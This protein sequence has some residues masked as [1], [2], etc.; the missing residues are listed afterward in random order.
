M[1]KSVRECEV[2]AKMLKLEFVSSRKPDVL[3][4]LTNNFEIDKEL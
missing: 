4:L 1:D 3:L 2:G